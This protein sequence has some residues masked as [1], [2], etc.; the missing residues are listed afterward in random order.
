MNRLLI[1][2]IAVLLGG[3]VAWLLMNSSLPPGNDA[4]PT[5]AEKEH[6][7]APGQPLASQDSIS[8]LIEVGT[9]NLAWFSDGNHATCGNREDEF[10]R[11]NADLQALAQHLESLDLEIIALQEIENTAAMERMLSFL[12][13][14]KYAYIFL[15]QPSCL[16]LAVLYQRDEVSLTFDSE[17]AS[18]AVTSGL[19]KALVVRGQFLPNGLDFRMVVVHLKAFEGAQEEET[20]RRQLRALNEWLRRNLADDEV[21]HDIVLLGDFNEQFLS[22]PDMFAELQQGI[23]LRLLTEGLTQTMCS[24]Q[25]RVYLDPIDHIVITGSLADEFTG[26]IQMEDVYEDS[27]IPKAVRDKFSDH[28]PLWGQ[29]TRLGDQDR[30]ALMPPE[31]PDNGKS[32]VETQTVI[33][34]NE[35]ELNPPCDDRRSECLESVELYNPS[36]ADADVSGW[37]LETTQGNTVTLLIPTSTVIQAKGYYVVQRARWL[38][39]EQESVILKDADGKFADQTPVQSDTKNDSNSWQRCPGRSKIWLFRPATISNTN[40]C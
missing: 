12:P 6:E 13:Q 19:R 39:N 8:Q 1:I 14:G 38:D 24:P 25:E 26:V 18:V 20:R 29:F 32:P 33:F 34:I 31:P 37:K 36:D 17:I 10:P 21:E 22:R 27:S 11:S 40:S 23:D 5:T 28:C 4:S 30:T 3:M 16:G 2:L 9:W 7:R 35:I 15:P